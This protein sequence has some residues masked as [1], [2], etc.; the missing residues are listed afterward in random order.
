MTNVLLEIDLKQAESRFVAYDGPVPKL[1]QMYLDGVDV[2]QYVAAHPFLFNKE[3]KNVTH[4]ERQLGKKTGHAANYGMSAPTLAVQCLKE[5]NLVMSAQRAEKML[6]GYHSAF[7]GMILR[8]QSNLRDTLSRTRKLTTPFGRERIFYDRLGPDLFKEAYAYR[9]QST[10]SDIINSL[11]LHLFGKP[12]VLL[13]NQIHDSLLLE[14]PGAHMTDVL[15]LI[16]DQDA[17]NP[18]LKLAG[19]ELRIPIEVKYGRR[20]KPME[21]IYEG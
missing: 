17:W 3:L 5:M 4:E 2:H 19:G 16:K 15:L 7:D 10:V 9:P 14:C 6:R 11:M 18:K 1:Q 21:V 13:L 8:W 12:H 20:W